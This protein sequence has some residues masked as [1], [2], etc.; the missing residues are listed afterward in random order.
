MS[1]GFVKYSI[2]HNGDYFKF[3]NSFYRGNN[4][5]KIRKIWWFAF[6]SVLLHDFYK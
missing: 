6:F 1:L 2:Y 3:S 4:T 5:I